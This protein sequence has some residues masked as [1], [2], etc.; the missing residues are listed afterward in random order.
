[1]LLRVRCVLWRGKEAADNHI[2]YCYKRGYR[3]IRL[4]KLR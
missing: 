2:D 3:V 1:M 4:V